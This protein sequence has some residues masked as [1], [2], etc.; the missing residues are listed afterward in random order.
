MTN[1]CFRM[2]TDALNIQTLWTEFNIDVI[3][4]SD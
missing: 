3:A 2:E 1:T 4:N